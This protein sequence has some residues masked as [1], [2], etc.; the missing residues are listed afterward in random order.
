M[1]IA[2][3]IAM[4]IVGY[5]VT[6]RLGRDIERLNWLSAHEASLRQEQEKIRIKRQL[7]SREAVDINSII[8]EIGDELEIMT[9]DEH[10]N[11]H[12]DFNEQVVINGN[13]SLIASSKMT[14]AVWMRGSSIVCSNASIEWTKDFRARWE[15]PVW[16]F[17]LSST[18]SSSMEASSPWRTE[19]PAG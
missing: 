17:R 15:A 11:L 7:I 6:R 10:F 18:L 12:I 16:A 9:E 4:N 19:S 14:D 3:S 1:L 13:L 2:V 5:F 8:A